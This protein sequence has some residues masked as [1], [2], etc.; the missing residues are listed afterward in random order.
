M[1]ESF[2]QAMTRLEDYHEARKDRLCNKAASRWSTSDYS[3]Y[4]DMLEGLE[5]KDISEAYQE[6]YQQLVSDTPGGSV[7]K[8]QGLRLQATF[9]ANLRRAVRAKL[10]ASVADRRGSVD[11]SRY[12]Y[13]DATS[14]KILL[15]RGKTWAK[16]KAGEV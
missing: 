11:Q 6:H 7:S 10:V 1:P 15:D 14:T 3:S 5:G 9:V 13:I 4:S 2:D 12:A 8:E 16:A